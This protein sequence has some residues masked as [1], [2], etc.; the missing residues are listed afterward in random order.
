MCEVPL[1]SAL[2]PHRGLAD[3]ISPDQI[4]HNGNV[5]KLLRSD[6]GVRRNSN[7]DSK[8]VARTVSG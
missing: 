3:A 1:N 7:G 2:L 8:P 4:F 6:G 5:A